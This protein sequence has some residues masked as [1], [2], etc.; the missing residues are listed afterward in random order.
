M[1]HLFDPLPLR[2]LTLGKRNP[3][4]TDVPAPSMDGFS[5][6][7]HFVHFKPAGRLAAPRWYLPRRPP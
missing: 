5:T 2:S 6:D 1:L 7:W 3:R 4:V